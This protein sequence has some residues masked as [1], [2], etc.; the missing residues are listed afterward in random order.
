MGLYMVKN[1][2]YNP[3][4]P[5]ASNRKLDYKPGLVNHVLRYHSA[6]IHSPWG[7]IETQKI[8]M[9]QKFLDKKIIILR[10][11]YF[12]SFDITQLIAA[13]RYLYFKI[14]K[15]LFIFTSYLS[16]LTTLFF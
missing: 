15:I 5:W 7:Y 13:L 14:F 10:H 3:T 16:F 1:G 8:S 6:A 2:T 4:S 11:T 12:L 9:A